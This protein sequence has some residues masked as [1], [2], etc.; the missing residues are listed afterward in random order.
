M[1]CGLQLSKHC[2]PYYTADWGRRRSCEPEG[3]GDGRTGCAALVAGEGGG[4]GEGSWGLGV[5]LCTLLYGWGRRRSCE[6]EGPGDQTGCA[7][8]VAGTGA[9][10]VPVK[11][12]VPHYTAN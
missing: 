7:C 10:R 5:P 11:H 2:V 8:L 1:P 4:G 9:V 6:P 3:P 12:C